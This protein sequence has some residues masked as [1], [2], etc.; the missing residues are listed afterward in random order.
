MNPWEMKIRRVSNGYVVQLSDEDAE[1]KPFFREEVFPD[2]EALDPRLSQVQTMEDLLFAVA[3]HF[4][5][6]NSK[7][8]KW[9]LKIE[10]VENKIE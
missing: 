3:G 4:S 6:F 7:H 5:C 8:D 9:N 10:V 1:G 2:V